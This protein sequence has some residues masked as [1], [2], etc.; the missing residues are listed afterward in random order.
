MST[1]KNEKKGG[2]L[3]AG[4]SVKTGRLGRRSERGATMVVVS[5]CLLPLLVMVALVV[6]LGQK[7]HLEASAQNAVDA[8]ALA[9]T[10]HV[11]YVQPG[12]L[13]HATT[14]AKE[15]VDQSFNIDE[16]S[17]DSC[18]D[19]DH[20]PTLPPSH[21]GSCISF[22]QRADATGSLVWYVKIR[23]P[24]HHFNTLFAGVFGQNTLTVMSYGG[25]DGGNG[26][27]APTIASTSTTLTPEQICNNDIT[28]DFSTQAN[29]LTQQMINDYMAA[30]PGADLVAQW[31]D[32]TDMAN[33][34]PMNTI[35]SFTLP[36][37]CGS[38]TQAHIDLWVQLWAQN[39]GYY[40]YNRCMFQ[41]A[42]VVNY[43]YSKVTAGVC[44][45]PGLFPNGY[46]PPTDTTTGGGNITSTTQ[47]PITLG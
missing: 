35:P 40:W 15:K 42:M 33:P 5:I 45:V 3:M 9:S 37:S 7:R 2:E 46:V 39:W 47:K 29:A 11:R 38:Q 14:I 17:W 41:Y 30:N 26:E 8:A 18:V 10:Y 36:G 19:P 43:D 25:A 4:E 32:Y 34:V 31:W 44:A 12:N 1:T 13:D 22:E 27:T 28:M 24:S 21:A 16:S 20:L 23:L 6:D